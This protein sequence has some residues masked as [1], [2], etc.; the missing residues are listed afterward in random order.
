MKVRINIFL[1]NKLFLFILGIGLIRK[2]GKNKISIIKPIYLSNFE[3]YKDE[4][5]ISLM[6]EDEKYIDNN[7]NINKIDN[8]KKEIKYVNSLI[9][10]SKDFLNLYVYKNKKNI[11]NINNTTNDKF[12]TYQ[13]ICDLCENDNHKKDFIAVKTEGKIKTEVKHINNS[14]K[15]LDDS[16]NFNEEIFSYKN[17]L[18]MSAGN[19]PIDLF[20]INTENDEEIFKKDKGNISVIDNQNKYDDI[21]NIDEN[22]LIRE[23]RKKSF[24]SDFSF[25]I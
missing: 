13:D 7:K 11:N 5:L 10:K 2:S 20:C 12:L 23:F 19:K 16:E 21:F 15:N 4:Q 17:L 14:S 22:S 8:L 25:G 6:E 3:S 24:F 9:S 1:Y 18:F